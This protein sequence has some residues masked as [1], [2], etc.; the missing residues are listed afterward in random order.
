[1]SERDIQ[2]AILLAA[3]ADGHRLFRNNSGSLQDRNGRW[4]SFG[5]CVGSSDLIG[6]SATGRFLAI[7]VKDKGKPTAEQLAFIAMV[8]RHDGLAGV[9][10]SVAEARAIWEQ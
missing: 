8:R 9:A 1:M 7:E 3:S 6:F 10:H 2:Q 4:V 5:L